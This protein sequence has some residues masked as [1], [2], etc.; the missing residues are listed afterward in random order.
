MMSSMTWSAPHHV[1]PVGSHALRTVPVSGQPR[2]AA[3]L[4]RTVAACLHVLQAMM[5][6]PVCTSCR[7]IDNV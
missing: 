3:L 1:T 7:R 6:P 2:D 5:V 4:S